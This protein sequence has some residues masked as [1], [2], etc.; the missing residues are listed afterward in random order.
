MNKKIQYLIAGAIMLLP[1]IAL[2]TPESDT[3]ALY[4]LVRQWFVSF[5]LPLGS[6]LAGL[7]ILVGGIM[8]AASGGDSTKTGRAKELIIGA[9]TGLVLLLSASLIIRTIVY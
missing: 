7:V 9:I 6:V 4:L 3:D 1:S 5:I 2:A 8:Y